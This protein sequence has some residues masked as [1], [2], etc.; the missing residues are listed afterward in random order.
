[1]NTL[2]V[3][4]VPRCTEKLYPLIPELSKL[5]EVDSYHIGEMSQETPWSGNIDLRIRYKAKYRHYINQFIEG[6]GFK[7]WGENIKSRAY[8]NIDFK[9][10]DLIIVDDSRREPH[11]NFK[12]L[13]NTARHHGIK[14]IGTPHANGHTTDP[15]NLDIYDYIFCYGEL[16]RGSNKRIVPAGYPSNDDLNK[17]GNK[18]HILVILNLL[19][20]RK[21]EWGIQHT[22]DKNF[23]EKLGL[24]EL[25]NE[26]NL[27]IV[28]KIKS[29]FFEK[30]HHGYD[31]KDSVN[32]I[33]QICKELEIKTKFVVD[34]LD[35]NKLI[36]QS[37][38]IIS[39]SP[40]LALK[41]IQ[42]RIPTAFIRTAGMLGIL[43]TYP[44][45]ID[46]SFSSIKNVY[47]NHNLDLILKF[48]ERGLSGGM[49]FN[50][51]SLY[52]KNIKKIIK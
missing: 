47:K 4:T 31:W 36:L 45:T 8:E 6:P 11:L 27:P 23:I 32:Y 52:I 35:N 16:D 19:G 15:R 28:F 9:K 3:F 39:C 5:G 38:F 10:Y 42:S 21:G 1:M 29:R 33:K 24:K 14:I 48:I 37:E 34:K 12:K 13:S 2:F 18:K 46:P 50:S 40:T 22:A 20:F 51:T 7:T 26:L 49:N 43:R 30:E 44:Y 17:K 41:G 25:Q